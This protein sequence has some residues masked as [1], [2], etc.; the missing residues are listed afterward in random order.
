LA[1]LTLAGRSVRAR[2]AHAHQ[3]LLL[4]RAVF[5]DQLAGHAAVLRQ[6]QQAGR[7]DIQPTG[8][9]EPSGVGGVKP[10]MDCIDS[11]SIGCT[12]QHCGARIAILGL[13]ADIADR[14]VQQDRHAASLFSLRRRIDL[15][16]LVRVDALP[17]YGWNAIDPDPAGR[18]PLIGLAPRRQAALGHHLGDPDAVGTGAIAGAQ[19]RN[20]NSDCIASRY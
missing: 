18:D 14:L 3:I 7:V 16:A 4:D 15:D 13:A 11:P 10:R 19:M 6:H 2:V 8:R 12:D 20:P 9:C 17:E 1:Q 5:A